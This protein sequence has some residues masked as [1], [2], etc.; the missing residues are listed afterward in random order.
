MQVFISWSGDRS[1]HI[2]LSFQSWLSSVIQ[3]LEPWVSPD[4]EKGA[5]WDATLSEKLETAEIGIICLTKDNLRAPYINYEAGALAKSKAAHVCT[6]LYDLKYADVEYPLA[7]F[8]HTE[9]SREDIYKL[10][11]TIN[12]LGLKEGEKK[13]SG[14]LLKKSFDTFWGQ[15][16]DDLAKTPILDA[17]KSGPQRSREA[18]IQEVL[19]I[20]RSLQTAVQDIQAEIR[21]SARTQKDL[22]RAIQRDENFR[23][24]DRILGYKPSIGAH[25][26]PRGSTPDDTLQGLNGPCAPS[27]GNMETGSSVADKEEPGDFVDGPSTKQP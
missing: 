18:M 3:R 23:K 22:S 17:S 27:P 11:A 8:Q 19:G 26:G 25:E 2:A 4:I 13:L 1:K 6:F 21:M 10:L 16:V 9:N 20:V 5:S 24:L 14:E 15:L 12:D 7:R